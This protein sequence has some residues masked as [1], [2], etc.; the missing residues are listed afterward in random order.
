[1]SHRTR[2][3]RIPQDRYYTPFRPVVPLIPHLEAYGVTTF[4]EPCVGGSNLVRHLDHFGIACTYSAD[5]DE[6]VDALLDPNLDGADNIITNPPYAWD[7]LAPMLNRFMRICPTWLLL[8]ADFGFN[9]RTADMMRYCTDVVPV[10]H[11]R[12]FD[13]TENESRKHYAWFRFTIEHSLFPKLH[14]RI[15]VPRGIR[16]A[17]DHAAHITRSPRKRR[18][19]E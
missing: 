14:P 18:S 4:S 11:V 17:A 6:G 15:A 5:L 1:M 2:F 16:S 13:D 9:A 10:G 19:A 12:W 3:E 8:E 7:V